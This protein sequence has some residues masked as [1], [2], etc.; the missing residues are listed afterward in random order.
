MAP[1][2]LNQKLFD[3]KADIFSI[4]VITYTLITGDMPWDA[5][6]LPE[7]KMK[8]SNYDPDYD[9]EA[10]DQVD[11]ICVDFL[12]RC[13]EKNPRKRWSAEQLL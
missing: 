11:Q 12:R 13:L 5:E 3:E 10:F 6:T 4:G 2:L 8:V 1:E 7:L 9:H